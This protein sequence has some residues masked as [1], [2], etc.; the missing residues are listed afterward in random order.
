M[1]VNEAIEALSSVYSDISDALPGALFAEREAVYYD[2]DFNEAAPEDGIAT[3]LSLG[4]FVSAAEPGEN[5]DRLTASSV[6]FEIS[7]GVIADANAEDMI[8]EFKNEA[9]AFLDEL[10]AAESPEGF[11]AAAISAAREER[12]KFEEGINR[13]MRRVRIFSFAA[14]FAVAAAVIATAIIL[15]MK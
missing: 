1:T 12:E 7:D 9:R 13:S 15:A 3:M 10:L 14:I 2:K 5:A 8:L 6:L 11:V 4:L